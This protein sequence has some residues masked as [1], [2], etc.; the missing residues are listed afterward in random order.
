MRTVLAWIAWCALSA[1]MPVASTIAQTPDPRPVATQQLAPFERLIGKRWHLGESSFQEFEWGV[2][3]RTVKARAYLIVDGEAKLVSEGL[4]F[5]HPGRREV[6]GVFTATG[7]PVTFFDYTT[8][9]EGDTIVS[10]LRAFGEGGEEQQYLET[11]EFVDDGRLSW[12]LFERRD[13]AVEES[14]SGIY[15]AR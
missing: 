14:M 3:R 1:C 4:W 5:W 8:R 11:W 10:D 6:K 9:F 12:T 15:V 7:M 2:D 13:G